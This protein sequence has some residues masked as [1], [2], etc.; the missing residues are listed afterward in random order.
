MKGKLTVI[1]Q[2]EGERRKAWIKDLDVE[3]LNLNIHTPWQEVRSNPAMA[4][5]L[6]GASPRVYSKLPG[7]L[8]AMMHTGSEIEL[9]YKIRF[10]GKPAMTD[11]QPA[12]F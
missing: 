4:A 10:R 3:D 11:F 7:E 6:A 8:L 2:P 9:I 1:F 5:A 12:L